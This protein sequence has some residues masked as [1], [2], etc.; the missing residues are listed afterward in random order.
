M[1]FVEAIC[2]FCIGF[3][4]FAETIFRFAEVI[5]LEIEN[6]NQL[7]PVNNVAGTEFGKNAVKFKTKSTN[8]STCI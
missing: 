5:C 7:S 8:N 6:I 4:H 2:L 1:H 3:M